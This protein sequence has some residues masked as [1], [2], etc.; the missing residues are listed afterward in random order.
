MKKIF[1]A[2]V[3]L[4]VLGVG[5]T[6][7]KSGIRRSTLHPQ[8]WQYNG[9]DV[10]LLGGS[11]EDNL[12]QIDSLTDHLDLLKRV[13]GNYVRNTMSSRDESNEWP[14]HQVPNGQYDLRKFNSNY[15]SR[16]SAFLKKTEER[17]IVV[18][19]EIWA[20]FDFYREPWGR[21]PFNPKNNSNYNSQR[22]KLSDSIGTHPIYTENNFFRSVPSQMNIAPVL[23]YQK[24]FVD[25]LLSYTLKH[26]HV[27]YCMDNETSVT[28]DWGRFWA[29]YIRKVAKLEGKTVETTEMWDP[30]DLSHPMHFETFDHPD[31]FSFVDISQNNHQGGDA[32]WINGIKQIEYL[33]KM[34]FLRPVNNVKIYGNDG[35]RHQTTQNAIESFCRNVLMGCASARFHRP[36]SGQ[37][38]NHIAQNVISS[39]RKVTNQLDFFKGYPIAMENYQNRKEGEVYGRAFDDGRYL[40][41]FPQGG[42]VRFQIK[43]SGAYRFVWTNILSGESRET[44]ERAVDRELQM[45]CPSGAHWL[46]IVSPV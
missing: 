34:D 36:S 1:P 12:F 45:E 37:G 9:E 39:V 7:E 5:H 28:T 6:Q 10:L 29:N 32:H 42:V 23:W 16:F 26:D 30:H 25:K 27:I 17:D 38:L 3:L 43:D 35:G 14:F 44:M 19:L 4:F 41:Y 15:W 8:Y 31:I 22:S 2:F 11:K 33:K 20:T 13:G 46:V 21:N 18:Q 40:F 24:R